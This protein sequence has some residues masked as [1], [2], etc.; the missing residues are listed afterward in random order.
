MEIS[1][2]IIRTEFSRILDGGRFGPTRW[3]SATILCKSRVLSAP[4]GGPYQ[5]LMAEVALAKFS[6]IRT[7]KKQSELHIYILL[8]FTTSTVACYQR[9]SNLNPGQMLVRVLRHYYQ[10]T[11]LH[12]TIRESVLVAAAISVATG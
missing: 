8:C 9:R 4:P 7:T 6:A 3:S 1:L 2:C 12:R 10:L 5:S 11:R